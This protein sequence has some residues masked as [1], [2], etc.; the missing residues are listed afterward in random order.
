MFAEALSNTISRST[1]ACSHCGLPVA[2]VDPDAEQQFC[3]AGCAS[4]FQI[5][6]ACSLDDYYRYRESSGSSARAARTSG[7]GYEELDAP[8]FARL[9]CKALEGGRLGTELFLENVHCA[10]CV[11]LVEKIATVLP[12]VAEARLDLSRGILR[13][14]WDPSVIRASRLAS[15]LDSIG[16]PSHPVHGLDRDSMRKREDR[17]LLMRIGV[18][19]AAAGNAML[20]AIALYS[21]AF[22]TMEH[23]YL[24]LFRWASLVV[25]LP[26]IFWSAAVF[27]RGALSALRTRTPHMDLP[28]SLG[29]LVGTASGVVNIVRAQGEIYFDT[30]TMLVFLLLV[31]R[32]LQQRQQR[33]ADSVADQ[34]HALA[35]STARILRAGVATDVPVESVAAGDLVEIRAGEHVPIDG[36][37]VEGASSIDASLLTGES[38]PKEVCADDVVHAGSVNL[39]ARLVV[40]AETAG[41]ETRLSR[42]VERVS[43]AAS[44]RAPVILLAN[45][46]SG[47]FVVAVLTVAAVTTIAIWHHGPSLAIQRAIALLVVTCPCALGLATPLAVSAALGRAAG[48]GLMIKGGEY[49][50]ALARPGLIVFDKTGTLTEG[51]LSLVDFVGDES[52]RPLVAAAE[53]GSAHPIAR[54]LSKAFGAATQL[55]AESM[56]E[57][58]GGGVVATV[59]GRHLVVG[60]AGFVRRHA[61][62]DAAW[63]RDTIERFPKRGLTP[64]LISVDDEVRAVAGVGDSVRADARESLQALRRLG[65]RLAILSGDQPAVVHAIVKQIGVPFDHVIGGASPEEKLAFVEERAREGAVF[66]VGD[67]VNDAAA[68]SAATV[69]IAVHGGAEASLAAADVFAT[70]SGLRPV[71]ELAEG[72]RRTLRVIRGNLARSL[73]YN[74][75]VGGLAAT[76]FVGPLLA[77]VLMPVSSLSVVASSYRARTFGGET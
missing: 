33:R 72:A 36:H 28:I 66:M 23:R 58:L 75:T 25:A 48:R 34:L 21:G 45:R 12:G 73:V 50:E 16:Y 1:A 46:L 57:T 42:L 68:L 35:P 39:A 11:W 70:K 63:L 71:V 49:L 19:F 2:N 4:V 67:G 10:A 61:S 62:I 56:R 40:R 76:G 51:H 38:L 47:Y 53:E 52:V 30:L 20:F 54:V 41:Q 43:E 60:S 13:I 74:L 65:H 24:E 32:W 69:G 18:A 29:I 22:S 64:V 7:R 59:S 27:H 6:K 26:S 8:D 77:A 15:W 44:R 55:R 9:Y 3:C 37:V 14:A 17:K 5:L 31:G